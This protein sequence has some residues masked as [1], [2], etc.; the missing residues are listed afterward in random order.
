MNTESKVISADSVLTQRI[1]LVPL[2]FAVVLGSSL[3]EFRDILIP[4]K[5]ASLNFWALV[6]V[7][8]SAFA[9]WFGY[10][11]AALRYPYTRRPI[12][13]LRAAVEAMVA[14]NWAFLLFFAT[15]AADSLV[16]YLWGFVM[17]FFLAT[18]VIMVRRR[19]WR[20]P[21]AG[22]QPLSSQSIY[23]ALMLATATAYSIW[24][25]LFDPIPEAAVWVFVFMPL[26]I[27]VSFRLPQE[28]RELPR[29]MPDE[30]E[31]S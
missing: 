20:L 11:E 30:Q 21:E 16:G 3:I 18:L 27:T 13:R 2:L 31:P 4:S 29:G 15:K 12:A 10:Q 14:I 6:T 28:L 19:E 24:A 5:L 8:L 22:Y 1:T 9:S 25:L 26:A 17:F 7:Y 23:G